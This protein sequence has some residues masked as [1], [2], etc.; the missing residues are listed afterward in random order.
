[1]ASKS[2]IN[3]DQGSDFSTSISISDDNGD[4]KD[5]TGYTC[6]SQIRKSYTSLTAVDFTINYDQASSGTF[7]LSLSS[8]TSAN[9]AAGRYV[10]DIIVIDP[11]HIITR[12]VE[13]IVTINPRVSV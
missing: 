7:G 5:L 1:M 4:P 8:N 11:E 12:V 13:G 9:M 2:N 3:I 6:K 10:Y